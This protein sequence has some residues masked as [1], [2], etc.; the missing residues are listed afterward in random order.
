VATSIRYNIITKSKP[1]WVFN[2]TAKTIE[3]D[4]RRWLRAMGVSVA[5]EGGSAAGEQYRV[6]RTMAAEARGWAGSGWGVRPLLQVAFNED[7]ETPPLSSGGWGATLLLWAAAAEMTTSYSERRRRLAGEPEPATT[8]GGQRRLWWAVAW[9][10]SGAGRHCVVPSGVRVWLSA[11]MC[12]WPGCACC[13][14]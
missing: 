1:N 10:G 7:V 13:F 9:A 3:I 11:G 6:G 8:V 5:G 14:G 2:P 12:V 4:L